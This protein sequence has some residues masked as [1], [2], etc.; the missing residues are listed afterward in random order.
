MILGDILFIMKK[1]IDQKKHFKMYKSGKTWVVAGI[2]AISL[3]GGGM[4][5]AHADE[6][7]TT[8]QTTVVS[9]SVSTTSTAAKSV[10][11]KDTVVADAQVSDTTQNST[12]NNTE[13]QATDTKSTVTSDTDSQNKTAASVTQVTEKPQ[14]DSANDNA[15]SVE[16]SINTD[17]QKITASTSTLAADSQKDDNTTAVTTT[18]YYKDGHWYLK[19]QNGNYLNGWQKLSG[20]RL[21]YYDLKNNQMLYGEQQINT[22]WFYLRKDNGDVVKGWFTLPDGRHVYYDVDANGG[23]NGMLHGIQKTPDNKTYYFNQ[24]TGA[25]ET[26]FKSIKGKTYYFAPEMVTGEKK[27][28]NHWYYFAKTGEMAIGFVTLDDTGNTRIVYYN[29]KGQMQYGEQKINNH[30][31]YFNTADGHEETGFVKLSDG[32]TVYYDSQGQMLYGNQKINNKQYLFN[33]WTGAMEKG[34]FLNKE[35]KYF[36]YYDQSD[37]TLT[38]NGTVQLDGKKYKIVDAHVCFP[39]GE[40]KINGYWYYL[41]DNKAMVGWISLTDGR[42]VHYDNNG[43]MQ[44]GEQKINNNW[45]YFNQWTGAAAIGWY[46]LPDGRIVYYQ[47]NKDGTGNGMLHGMATVNGIAYYFNQWTGARENGFKVINGKTYY[48]NPQLSLGEKN[49]S[50]HWYYFGNNGVMRTGFTSLPDGR[51][52][53]YN[54][55]GQMQYGEQQ[56]S[57]KWYCFNQW[58]GDTVRGW[59]TLSD[60]RVVYYQVNNDGTGAGM[61]H[62]M[63]K[64]ADKYYYF[65]QWTGARESGFKVVNG[66]TYYFMPEMATGEQVI[67]GYHYYFDGDGVME[68]GFVS[69]PDGRSVYYNEKG[70]MQFG[71]QKINGKWFYFNKNGNIVSDFFD[72]PDGRRVYYAIDQQN[73]ANSK[74][75]LYGEQTVKG[76][77][78]YFNPWTGAQEKGVVYN[79]TTKQLQYYGAANGSLSKNVETTIAKKKVKTDTEGNII[80]TNGENEV[81][82]QWYYYDTQKKSLI[83]GWK[84][85]SDGREV[86]YDPDTAQMIHGEKK[87]S[88]FWFYFDKWT[89]AEA[90][91]QFIKLADGRIAYYDEKGHMSYDE[92]KIGNYWYYFN[93]NDGNEA[94][95]K[96]IKLS[97][98]RTVYY[99]SQGHMVY[100]WQNINGSTYYFNPQTGGMYVGAQWINGQEYYFD[101]ITG[102]QVKDQWTA[103]L[104]EWF[105]NRIG[106]LTYSMTGSRNGADGTADC[107]GSLT[108]AL[109]EA[110]AWRYSM[111]Y[112]TEMLHSYLLGNGYHLA[113]ENTGYTSPLVGDVIIWGQRGHS[114]GGAGHTGVISGSGHE[115]T[116]I[117]TCYWTEGEHGTAVQNF[118]YFWYWGQDDY[119]YYYV[120]RR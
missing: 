51:L 100:N 97:D 63:Q 40:N 84:K 16:Q 6:V 11:A 15:Q 46:T 98:G 35:S 3:L 25:Q 118:P 23:G 26:G 52:V 83:T 85:L 119:P 27:I 114:A 17:S 1:P 32:R 75:M 80:L 117:S 7:S 12:D 115:G 43:Q 102:A 77:I 55:L 4:Q 42:L 111:L 5:I 33:Q 14:V 61:L 90:A 104:L 94:V 49:I 10:T 54:S 39:N 53:Y 48:F 89:G 72:L 30:W 66:N 120:Y 45:Y 87:I 106:K 93:L 78:Y 113:Y 71:E 22:Q 82:G 79:S 64:A 95:S 60:G 73:V 103:K 68:T 110:G 2:T 67:G 105:F 59:H 58:N 74:G 31:Y 20:N 101:Y 44:Y 50:G 47:V 70:Q 99:D 96:F 107:S 81:N 88:G 91:S 92:K 62:G 19:D 112:N 56:I 65:N 24:W 109:Y 13:S 69:L 37:G 28:D 41:K 8:T 18:E 86:Y 57:G 38:E 29:A 76:M 108:Q 21:A 9:P 116:M 34:V 36:Q